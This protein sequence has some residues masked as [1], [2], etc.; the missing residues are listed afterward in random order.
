L[1]ALTSVGA[2]YFSF[3]KYKATPIL[4]KVPKLIIPKT[5]DIA[6]VI[7]KVWFANPQHPTALLLIL[8][9]R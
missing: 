6:I 7:S 8:L 4:K 5:I 9:N 1:E 3:N 2:F